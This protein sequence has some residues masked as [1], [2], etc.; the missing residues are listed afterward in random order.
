MVQDQRWL[1]N[2]YYSIYFCVLIKK[3][4]VILNYYFIFLNCFD[5]SILKI[6]KY[7]DKFF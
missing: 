7:F 1:I 5:M 6:K 4:F 3:N 2:S